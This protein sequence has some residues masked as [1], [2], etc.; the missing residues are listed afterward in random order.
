MTDDLRAQLQGLAGQLS[1]LGEKADSAAA[2]RKVQDERLSGIEQR[3]ARVE[4]STDTDV[5]QWLANH[6]RTT[7]ILTPSILFIITVLA[8][9]VWQLYGGTVVRFLQAELREVAN[10]NQILF[11]PMGLSF[12]RSPVEAGGQAEYI[13]VAR[14]TSSGLTCNYVDT[15]PIFTDELGR[16]FPGEFESRG[17]Q[18]GEEMTRSELSIDVPSGLLPGRVVVVLQ[19]IYQCNGLRL[20]HDT[21]PVAFELL[22]PQM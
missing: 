3:L 9:G 4:K 18:Y 1:T 19:I 16:S 10:E 7:L 15:L 12:V 8:T 2:H 22:P 17:W 13:L 14:R 11:Q 21:Y 5:W 6:W 20:T